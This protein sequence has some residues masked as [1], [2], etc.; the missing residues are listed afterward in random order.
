MMKMM[1]NKLVIKM[2][3]IPI[4]IKILTMETKA[5]MWVISL[6]SRKKSQPDQG[7]PS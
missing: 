3:S 2:M 4:V 1:S 6:F 7:Q 5:L